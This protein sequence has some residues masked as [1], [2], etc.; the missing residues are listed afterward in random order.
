MPVVAVEG[1]DVTGPR[2]PRFPAAAARSCRRATI[3]PP[4]ARAAFSA[5]AVAGDTSPHSACM[6]WSAV[7]SALTGRK[8]PA[9]T[10]SVTKCVATPCASRRAKKLRREMQAGGRR[11]DRA[12]LA[13]IDRLVVVA[14]AFV[15]GAR[16]G[17]IGRQRHMADGG[18]RLVEDRAGEVE[19][20]RRPRRP[21][22][23]PQRSPRVRRTDRRR[24][25]RRKDA[26]AGTQLLRRPRTKARQRS[27]ATAL[28]QRRADPPPSARPRAVATPSSWAGMTRVSL[29]TSTSPGRSR[30][31]QVAKRCRSSS[32]SPGCDHQQPR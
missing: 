2:R 3:R 19:G 26:V 22:P 4:R 1:P 25:R 12:V 7:S 5:S 14:V 24:H 16:G 30:S 9:P 28:M 21:R 13:G 6:R 17:D 32:P 23:F 11:R 18:D 15:L 27:G 31:R 20:E 10:C 8:V 29:K